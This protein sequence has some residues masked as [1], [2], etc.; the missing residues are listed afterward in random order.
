MSVKYDELRAFLLNAWRETVNSSTAMSG[1][2]QH[3]RDALQFFRMGGSG[4]RRSIEVALIAHL[5]NGSDKDPGTLPS[6]ARSQDFG[7][8]MLCGEFGFLAL[9]KRGC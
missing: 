9:H 5:A 1:R 7:L 6:S 8:S 2:G 3:S 4:E